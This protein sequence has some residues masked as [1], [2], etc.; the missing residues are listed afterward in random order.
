MNDQESISKAKRWFRIST[1][2]YIVSALGWIVALIAMAI[3][4]MQ[5]GS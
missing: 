5:A 3:D 4:I 2:G 1:I